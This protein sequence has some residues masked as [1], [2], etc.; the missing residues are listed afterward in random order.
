VLWAVAACTPMPHREPSPSPSPPPAQVQPRHDVEYWRA[1]FDAAAPGLDREAQRLSTSDD[2]SD[3]YTLAYTLDAFAGM[4]EATGEAAYADRALR[5]A[6]NMVASA[7]PSTSLTTSEFDDDYLGWTS[8]DRDVRGEEVAL[9]ESYAWR[10]VTR[11]LRVL[12]DSPLYAEPDYRERYDRL[13]AFTE[14]NIFDK[15]YSRGPGLYIYRSRTHMAAHWAYIAL[16]LSVL[17]T[18]DHRR[19]RYLEVVHDIDDA[20]PGYPSS[21]RGQLRHNDADPAAY[22][23]SARWG[24]YDGEAQ[25]VAHGNGVIAYVVEARD[26]DAGWSAKELAGFTR[27]LTSFVLGHGGAYPGDVDGTGEGNGWIADGFVKLGRYDPAVQAVLEDYSVQNEQYYAAMAVNAHI[28][29]D[30]SA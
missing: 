29:Q 22:W 14:R 24:R 16:D 9:Y 18:D 26:L 7:R 6:E 25:D 27:T 28:L 21:L 5:Y 19:A 17:T 15:W 23:W 1:K 10:Y 13:L 2:S 4:F 20:L 11:L 3:F 8:Q 12:H 30:R